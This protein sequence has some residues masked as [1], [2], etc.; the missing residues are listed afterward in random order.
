M[1]TLPVFDDGV[2]D[3]RVGVAIWRRLAGLHKQLSVG[4]GGGR[5]DL[6]EHPL[7]EVHLHWV[8]V[9]VNLCLETLGFKKFKLECECTESLILEGVRVF[10]RESQGQVA[11]L[12]IAAEEDDL[13]VVLPGNYI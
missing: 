11:L 13:N 5:F 6:H 10:V 4:D 7:F 1:Y 12:W 9:G 2:A 8:H 3:L